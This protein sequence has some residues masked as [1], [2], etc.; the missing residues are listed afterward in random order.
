MVLVADL[1]S[2]SFRPVEV[3]EDSQDGVRERQ[4]ANCLVV[5]KE[6]GLS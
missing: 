1:F 5:R 2:V 3:V 4:V 6:V